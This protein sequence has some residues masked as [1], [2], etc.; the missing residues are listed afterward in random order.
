MMSDSA[1]ILGVGRSTS[2]TLLGSTKAT[3]F[4]VSGMDPIVMLSGCGGCI[5]IKCASVCAVCRVP[6][7]VWCFG[8]GVHDDN[9]RLLIS[10]TKAGVG[11]LECPTSPPWRATVYAAARLSRFLK[12]DVLSTPIPPAMHVGMHTALSGRYLY[13][14]ELETLSLLPHQPDCAQLGKQARAAQ[15]AGASEIM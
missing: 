10:Y 1:S 7:T 8:E 13:P 6:Q 9:T 11:M 3:A 14:P 4:I 15:P 2:S 5:E 12:A